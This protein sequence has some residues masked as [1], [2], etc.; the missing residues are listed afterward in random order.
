MLQTAFFFADID[1]DKHLNQKEYLDFQ[2]PEESNNEKLKFHVTK[3]DVDLRC[4]LTALGWWLCVGGPVRRYHL[5]SQPAIAL[6]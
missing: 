6:G 1:G 4:G 5:K 2:N 3:Q